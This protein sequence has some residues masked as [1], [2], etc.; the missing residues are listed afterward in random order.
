MS[1]F[2]AKALR[3]A[4]LYE[5]LEALTDGCPEMGIEVFGKTMMGRNI[6]AVTVGEGETGLLLVSG[7]HA[8]EWITGLALLRFLYELSDAIRMKR[9]IYGLDTGFLLSQKRLTVVPL[10]NIDGA[11]LSIDGLPGDHPL[12]ERLL[13]M[14][15]GSEDFTHWQ[16]NARGVDLNHNYAAG[17][18]EYR[19]IEAENGIFG[20]APTKYSGTYPE[21]EPE[22]A[23]LCALIRSAGFRAVVSLHTQG[24][25]VYYSTL[26]YAPAGARK[27]AEDIVRLTGYRLSAPSGTAAY[28]G[29]TDWFITEF[30]RPAFTLEC[31]KGKSPLPLE[32]ELGIY[33]RL[34]RFLFTL[35]TMV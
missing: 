23:A 8:S 33:L 20:G 22:T 18:A 1:G 11:A 35:P 16:A 31:G 6:P 30:D 3:C 27:T 2:T 34:R 12:R 10:L 26:G 5:Y 4:D 29:L 9:R 14:N 24:E 17:F 28:G 19:K 32:S 15:G 21:S 25:E 13:G 7:H